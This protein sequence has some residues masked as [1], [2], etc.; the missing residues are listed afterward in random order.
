VR[1]EIFEHA[2]W[3]SLDRG[4]LSFEQAVDRGASRT[5]LPQT[6]IERLLNEV[7]PS[8]API[9]QTIDLIGELSQ[10]DNRLF[11]LSNMHTA[12]IEYLEEKYDIWRHF[13]GIVISSRI[14]LVKPEIAIYEHLLKENRLDA[15]DTVFID[16]T[17]VNLDAAASTGIG[18]I[19][20]LDPGQCREELRR[21]LG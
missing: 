20:F 2:D 5:G 4:T 10:T 8:L 17:P 6:E 7:P 18:T 15:A 13:D 11:V 1:K 3:V 21:F 19:Q 16:D 14:R 9:Q 12:S